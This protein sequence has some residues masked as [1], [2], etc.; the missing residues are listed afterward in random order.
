[1]PLL[2]TSR[3]PLSTLIDDASL[4]TLHVTAYVPAFL[5]IGCKRTSYSL[6]GSS[7]HLSSSITVARGGLIGNELPSPISISALEK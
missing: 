1:M 5:I 4:S 2:M 6:L 3:L 7:L